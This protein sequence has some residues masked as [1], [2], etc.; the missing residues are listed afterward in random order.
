MEINSDIS[1]L[2]KNE[3]KGP[4]TGEIKYNWKNVKSIYNLIEILSFLN[5]KLK[6]NLIL[7]SKE[8]QKNLGIDIEDYKK[9]NGKYIIGG[10]NG[11]GKELD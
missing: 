11:K 1:I 2:T 7:R 9:I 5:I 8:L 3:I 10:R 6:L 4:K